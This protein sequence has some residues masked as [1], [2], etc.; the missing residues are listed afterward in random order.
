VGLRFDDFKAHA[1]AGFACVDR[2]YCGHGYE[3]LFG[4]AAEAG[5]E[6]DVVVADDQAVGGQ[7]VDVQRDLPVVDVCGGNDGVGIDGDHDVGGVA[8]IQTPFV[9]CAQQV[10]FGGR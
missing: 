9:Q 4:D 3:D 5:L 10:G 7:G 6:F 1:G 8:V 2:G